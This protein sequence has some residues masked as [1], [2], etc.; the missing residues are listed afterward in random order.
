MVGAE[1]LMRWHYA[2]R[3]VPPS[4]FIPLAEE[5]GLITPLSEWAVRE[6]AR[7]ARAWQISFGFDHAIAVNLPNRLFERSDLVEQIH[8]AVTAH[9]VSPKAI[10]LEITETGL[11]K[12]LHS[13]VRSLHRLNE[14]GVNI[15]I[16]DF[17]TGYSSLAY[18]TALPISELKIDRSFIRDL[19]VTPQ[20]SA[21]VTAIIA[22]ARSLNLRVVGE[23]VE[24]LRQMDVLRR[25]G[26]SVMQG[27][28]FSRPLPPVELEIWLREW[29][30]TGRAPWIPANRSDRGATEP[31]PSLAPYPPAG[32]SPAD[33]AGGLPRPP[34][35]AREFERAP[36]EDP[37]VSS[38]MVFD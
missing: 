24:N 18:L 26:C 20:S 23:G 38:P 17:G 3:L 30:M 13:V 21:V 2:G 32:V 8:Q 15:A 16:D 34:L 37:P 31:L 28:L 5:A 22:L 35:L 25:L 6:A 12:D 10:Q 1:A 36:V 29:V 9:G 7:Q 11:M 33:R 14:L 4:E 27:F 19:G